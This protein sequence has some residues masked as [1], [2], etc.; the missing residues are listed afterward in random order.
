LTR[1]KLK[2]L[3]RIVGGRRR[4][5]LSI[6]EPLYPDRSLPTKQA[7]ADLQERAIASMKTMMNLPQEETMSV[8]MAFRAACIILLAAQVFRLLGIF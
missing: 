8:S 1:R 5:Q 3:N 4:M 7:V 2:G 6:G